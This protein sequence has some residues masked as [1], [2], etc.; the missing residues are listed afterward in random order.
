M[1]ELTFGQEAC[2]SQHFK[3]KIVIMG[4][5]LL[6]W[7]SKDLQNLPLHKSNENTSKNGQ[8]QFFYE[9]LKLSKDLQQ[10][11]KIYSRKISESM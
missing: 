11:R 10:S 8:N 5:P 2:W 4:E 7:W 6:E 3:N 9:L 1:W